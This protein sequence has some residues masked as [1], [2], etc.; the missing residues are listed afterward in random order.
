MQQ[1]LLAKQRGVALIIVLL[2][3]A[4]VSVLATEMGSRLQLQVKR[5]ANIKENNQ[6]YWYAMGAEQYA[7][8]SINLLIEKSN[9]VI[10]LN[11]PWSEEFVYPIT[12]GGIQAQLFDMHACFN[13]NALRVSEPQNDSGNNGSGIPSQP[14]PVMA[15]YELLAKAEI[16]IP[17]FE[18]ETLRDSLADWMDEDDYIQGL[19]AE[20][21]DYESKRFPYLAANNLMAHKSE[22]RMVNGVNLA[23]LSKL[24]PLVC[25]IPNDSGLKINVNT[26]SEKG[27]A[28]LAAATGLD[29]AKAKSLLASRPEDGWQ[30]PED[31]LAEKDVTALATLSDERKTWFDVT[32]NHFILHTRTKYNNATF[33]MATVFSVDTKNNVTV[34]RREFGGI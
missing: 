1:Q 6:A 20:D 18:A 21:R 11:Q 26:L 12:G 5:A 34:L 4:I 14:E 24:M 27:A 13:L 3:V 2:I 17:S 22:L 9:G 28:I 16:E 33:S 19:G 7:R 8:K 23:W 32:S 25:A 30:K 31:F 29:L 15:F 10:H